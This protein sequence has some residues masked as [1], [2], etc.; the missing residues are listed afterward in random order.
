MCKTCA[1]DF[2]VV[3]HCNCWHGSDVQ[4]RAVGLWRA[5]QNEVVHML[6][7]EKTD[8]SQNFRSVYNKSKY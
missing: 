7:V 8:C 5:I 4:C 6:G 1:N 3:L 2:Y